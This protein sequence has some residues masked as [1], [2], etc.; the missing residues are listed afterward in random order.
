MPDQTPTIEELWAEVGFTPNKSQENAIR[1]T[2]GP[3]FLTAGPGSG[4]TRVILWKTL[5]LIVHHG[6]APDHIFLGTFTEKA[7]LQLK[8][9][10]QSLLGLVTN[11][12]NKAFDL[13][14]MYVGTVH[15]LCNRLITDRRF[16]M[17]GGASKKITPID[18]LEQYFHISNRKI[19]NGIIEA[20]ELNHLSDEDQNEYINDY[21]AENFK[22]GKSR[23]N[24]VMHLI[25]LFNR[26]TEE[27]LG[28]AILT[29]K[30]TDE[31]MKKMVKM[32]AYY[33]ESLQEQW[34]EKIDFSLVQ[35]KGLEVMQD[36]R[37]EDDEK[38]KYIIIDEYQDTN[39]IQERLFF[40][41]AE[42]TQNLCV[43]G[44][45]DQALYR[46]RGATV[47]NFVD[48]EKRCNQYYP[49]GKPVTKIALNT[50]YRSRKKIVDFYTSFIDLTNWQKEGN[51]QEQYRVH[52]KNIVAHSS[53][54]SASVLT[55]E[56]LEPTE[57]FE[58]IAQFIRSLLNAEIIEDPNQ[59]AFLFPS[60]GS[61][62]VGR[63][64]EALENVGLRTYAPRAQPF[65]N[66]PEARKIMG[67]FLRIFGKPER[68]P[69]FDRGDFKAYHDWIEEV[70]SEAGGAMRK[71]E[72]LKAL[73]EHHRNEIGTSI[74][75]YKALL[76]QAEKASL[77]L[78]DIYDF[79]KMPA[80]LK[81]ATISPSAKKSLA[82]TYLKK[83]LEKQINDGG[84]S[85]FTLQ[86][87]ITRATSLDWNPLDL[88]YKILAF[89]D[90]K[91]MMDAAEKE[92]EEI[93]E[94]PIY[95]LGLLTGYISRFLEL[96]KTVLRAKDL[97]SKSFKRAF[98]IRFWYTIYKKGETEF[99]NSED[100]F[101]RGRIPFLT[102]HQ[103]KGLE[104]PLVVLG[105]SSTRDTGPRR[106]EQLIRPLLTSIGEP[107]Q[108]MNEFDKARMFYVALSR[109][110][111]L[112]IVSNYKRGTS[113]EFRSLLAQKQI[114]LINGFDI[115]TIPKATLS[116][117][118]PMKPY[119]YTSDY[120][121]YERCPRQYM[122]F[123]K[124][125]FVPSRSQ[126][127][128]FGSL[129]HQTI[130]DLHNFIIEKRKELNI[131]LL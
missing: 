128:F 72:G 93:D 6:V 104:F 52:T 42:T 21:L 118:T 18:D 66:L 77:V 111:N 107:L 13:S 60:L 127:M 75:D 27:C 34:Q 32:Y 31:P 79:E 92:N 55:T 1:H 89:K 74:N 85:V 26:F 33:L 106:M 70:Y 76:E 17:K 112:L 65:L 48:F 117:K 114:P 122:I 123:R 84:S 37:G 64:Q 98:F 47:E 57:C 22:K 36:F 90:F 56:N 2:D 83:Q 82:S 28:V 130:D 63:A 4:K 94:G 108:R 3:L 29:Q 95:N 9:G 96:Y 110:E 68:D 100:P 61:T 15:S 12:T 14:K 81:E 97:S 46:F 62:Q 10:L 115:T 120:L 19:W 101:P 71:D 119:S 116:A 125:G 30:V 25:A 69:E 80:V 16:G 91:V 44:D 20:G 39:T 87:V 24:A 35:Q 45:D 67:I 53:D 105:N 126:T 78:E 109:A 49:G 43:V 99:E 131:D 41:L 54:D 40:K 86:D 23:Y 59:V 38:F 58:R 103:S 7:A 5:H 124:Y 113:K 129:V 121:L 8:E 73:V 50:N 11:R 51:P 88:F 102:I